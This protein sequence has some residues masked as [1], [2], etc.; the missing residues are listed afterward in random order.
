MLISRLFHQLSGE[1]VV[2]FPLITLNLNVILLAYL[3]DFRL[4]LRIELGGE[5]ENLIL[6]VVSLDIGRVLL[7]L[8]DG[9]GI[10]LR[11][12]CILMSIVL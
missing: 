6:A 2:S 1:W 4:D 11:Y 8:L 5:A 12:G 10:V 7:G 9:L 3:R